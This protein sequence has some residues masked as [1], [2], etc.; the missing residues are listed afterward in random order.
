MEIAETSW[1]RK[2]KFG[3]FDIKDFYE[4]EWKNGIFKGRGHFIGKME[5]IMRDIIGA[6]KKMDGAN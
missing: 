2:L 6:R 4:G 5:G 3:I 1:E